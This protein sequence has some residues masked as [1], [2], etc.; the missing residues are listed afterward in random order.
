MQNRYGIKTREFDCPPVILLKANQTVLLPF[1]MYCVFIKR[2]LRKEE[3]I[4]TYCDHFVS[5]IVWIGVIVCF[6][7]PFILQTEFPCHDPN[8]SLVRPLATLFISL[9]K[10]HFHIPFIEKNDREGDSEFIA[11]WRQN[12][13]PRSIS[14][15]DAWLTSHFCPENWKTIIRHIHITH[16]RLLFTMKMEGTN[17]LYVAFWSIPLPKA[18]LKYPMM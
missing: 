1:D 15:W 2:C 16:T 5:V 18:V 6:Q 7:T 14:K 3:W 10:W 17:G 9:Q 13:S 4:V 11:L 12:H 8:S